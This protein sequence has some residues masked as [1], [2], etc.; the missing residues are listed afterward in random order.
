MLFLVQVLRAKQLYLLPKDSPLC[1][2]LPLKNIFFFITFCCVFAENSTDIVGDPLEGASVWYWNNTDLVSVSCCFFNSC[3][4]TKQFLC[5]SVHLLIYSLFYW[6]LPWLQNLLFGGL[7]DTS[8]MLLNA[9]S[10]IAVRYW[11]VFLSPLFQTELELFYNL[12]NTL[13]KSQMPITLLRYS[14]LNRT[15]VL[16]VFVFSTMLQAKANSR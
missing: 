5:Y 9:S 2:S 6:H 7:C 12:E 10:F 3:P 14:C 15:V 8:S 16:C 4:L 13:W 1:K 11:S